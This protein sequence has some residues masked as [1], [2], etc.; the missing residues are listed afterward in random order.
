[1]LAQIFGGHQLGA[2]TANAGTR[3][4][5]VI[6]P[7]PQGVTRVTSIDYGDTGTAH[8]ITGMRPLGRTKLREAA[9][10]SQATLKLKADP[11]PSGNTIAAS[12]LVLIRQDDGTLLLG[13]VDTG[14]W[15]SSTLT[16]TLAASLTTAISAGADV[17]FMGVA[18]DTDPKT[19]TVFPSVTSGASTGTTSWSDSLAGVFMGGDR[20][21]P[22]ILSSANGTNAGTFKKVS[23]G[24]TR[25]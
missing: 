25:D 9:A 6:P 24:Y 4:N 21:E 17:W 15:A 23:V 18:G 10:A 1:M 2:K 22:L 14:G 7:H 3:I 19:G 20:D 12:D 11:S 16:V 5:N 13:T 8:V